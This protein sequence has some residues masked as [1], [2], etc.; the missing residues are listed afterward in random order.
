MF[1]YFIFF[2]QLL[3]L[4]TPTTLISRSIAQLDSYV[5][6]QLSIVLNQSDNLNNFFFA[7]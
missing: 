1:F 5:L 6:H 7:I 2:H 4:T 3:I